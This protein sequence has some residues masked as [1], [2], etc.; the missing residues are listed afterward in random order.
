VRRRPPSWI[1]VSSAADDCAVTVQHCRTEGPKF[2]ADMRQVAIDAVTNDAGERAP[3]RVSP[4]DR[5]L[6]FNIGASTKQKTNPSFV[7]ALPS[8]IAVEQQRLTFSTGTRLRSSKLAR[9]IERSSAK[10]V[11]ETSKGSLAARALSSRYVE[12]EYC[13]AG[14]CTSADEGRRK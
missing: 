5:V 11:P 4:D 1:L 6:L 2:P 3:L 12:E 7:D 8:P 9:R 14:Y 10:G 13:E